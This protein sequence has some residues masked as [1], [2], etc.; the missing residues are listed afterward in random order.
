MTI[1]VDLGRKA[2]KQTNK[3]VTLLTSDVITAI[4]YPVYG[5]VIMIRTVAMALS[6]CIVFLLSA[7][8]TCDPTSFR[9]HNSHCIPGRWHCDN[10]HDC[11]D[12]S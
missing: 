7:K 9:C 3:H 5:T 2:T 10:D 4:V 8:N 6:L 12:G 11:S 1:A